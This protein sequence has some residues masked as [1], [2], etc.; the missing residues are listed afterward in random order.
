[1]AHGPLKSALRTSTID[2][3]KKSEAVAEQ[4]A[5]LEV[6]LVDGDLD[7]EEPELELLDN[8]NMDSCDPLHLYFHQMGRIP[9]LSVVDERATA[10]KI[11]WERIYSQLNSIWRP[12]GFVPPRVWFFKISSET[13]CKQLK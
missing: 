9:L 2:N 8:E 13:L 11:E 6:E 1:M 4:T 12:K 7:I 5:M 10:R 3:V